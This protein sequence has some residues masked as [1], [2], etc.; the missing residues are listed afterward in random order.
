MCEVLTL[1]RHTPQITDENN[2]SSSRWSKKQRYMMMRLALEPFRNYSSRTHL[3]FPSA[4]P[5]AEKHIVRRFHGFQYDTFF[6]RKV[7]APEN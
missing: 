5:Q 1:P 7:I 6:R 3:L 4:L 2:G